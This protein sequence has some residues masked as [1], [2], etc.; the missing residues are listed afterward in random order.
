[1]VSLI[2]FLDFKVLLFDLDMRGDP[3]GM[4]MD[5]YGRDFSTLP[6]DQTLGVRGGF[7]SHDNTDLQY[8]QDFQNV[9]LPFSE[10]PSDPI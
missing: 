8:P 2:F 3:Y 6:R 9:S 5:P 7:E 10:N 1:M 4:D